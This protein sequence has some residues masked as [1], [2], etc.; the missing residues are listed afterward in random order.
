[1]SLIVADRTDRAKSYA[2]KR[3]G[4]GHLHDGSDPD[5]RRTPGYALFEASVRVRRWQRLPLR[6]EPLQTY[7]G[8]PTSA[9]AEIRRHVRAVHRATGGKGTGVLDRGFDRRNLFTPWGRRGGPSAP[10]W[11]GV[12]M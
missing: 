1:D 8:A 7:A 4:L 6:I 3:E 12:A 5:Q 11:W 10:A 2:Q 9:N